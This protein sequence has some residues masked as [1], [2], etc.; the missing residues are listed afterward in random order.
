MG[1]TRHPRVAGIDRA[2]AAPADVVWQLLADV[3]EWPSW[4][5]SVRKAVL[6]GG[7]PILSSGA[8]GTV[9]TVAGVTVP[10][11]ITEFVPARRWC[12][13]VAG[14]TATGHEVTPV[15]EGCRVR[16]EVP[17]WATPYLPVCALGLDRLAKLAAASQ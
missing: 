16:F 14:V 8:R 2:I 12:W 7:E 15:G 6:H 5:P 9:W 1:I 13:K 10:F 4:G 17:W 11:E 3:R